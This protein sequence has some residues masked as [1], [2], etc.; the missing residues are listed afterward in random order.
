MLDHV[1]RRPSVR[2]RIGANPLGDWLPNDIA[3]LE[4]RGH[5][6]KIIQQSVRAVEANRNRIT[7]VVDMG[8]QLGMARRGPRSDQSILCYLLWSVKIEGEDRHCILTRGP[9]EGEDRHCIFTETCVIADAWVPTSG[10]CAS[11]VF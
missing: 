3:Y 6:P 9:I 11:R 2:D 8:V 10:G 1:F 5:L 7:D 4:V